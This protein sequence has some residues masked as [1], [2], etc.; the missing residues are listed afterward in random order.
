MH[1]LQVE[2]FTEYLL[3]KG[4]SEKTRAQL[5]RSVHRFA[6]WAAAETIELE[7]VSYNDVLA[8][9][10]HCKQKGNSQ[11]TQ[12]IVVN[13]IKHYYKFLL[14]REAVTENPCSNVIIKGVKRKTLYQ[15]FTVEELETIYTTYKSEHPLIHKRNKIILGLIIYQGIRTEEL[16]MLTVNDVKTRE[17]K[18][19][20]SGSRKH[21]ARDLT[22]EAHQLYALLDY[23]NDT[24]NQLLVQRQQ[25]SPHLF[26]SL[27]KGDR[28]SNMLHKLIKQLTRQDKRIKAIKQLRASVI[29]H[30]LK[31]YNIRKVQYMAGHRYVSS[32]ESYQVNN[33][34]DLIEDVNRYHPDL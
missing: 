26:I 5:M 3:I 17:G 13:S 34:D 29:T 21:N 11:R 33:M 24:R 18:L 4:M 22:L 10:Q 20:I 16:A 31:V 32:T 30:W 25:H 6:R 27:G 7:N 2:A 12:Q 9:V 15:T 8:Y 19:H 14:S 23:I 1:P 28:I